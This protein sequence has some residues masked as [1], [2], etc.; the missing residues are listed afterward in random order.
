MFCDSVK[1]TFLTTPSNEFFSKIQQHCIHIISNVLEKRLRTFDEI[2]WLIF[3]ANNSTEVRVC[4]K[5]LSYDQ[6]GGYT[7]RAQTQTG[8]CWKEFW[9]QTDC[10]IGLCDS[11]YSAPSSGLNISEIV[12]GILIICSVILLNEH[13]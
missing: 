5:K 13:L 11:Y 4:I 1:W 3:T 2:Y 12:F 9:C 6:V 8:I 10:Q 7:C